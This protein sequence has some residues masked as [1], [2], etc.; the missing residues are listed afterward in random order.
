VAANQIARWASDRWEIEPAALTLED[1]DHAEIARALSDAVRRGR[2]D[3]VESEG[4][5]RAA[6]WALTEAARELLDGSKP[7]Q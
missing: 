6:R 7:V 1:L 4:I 2:L 3:L 5:G